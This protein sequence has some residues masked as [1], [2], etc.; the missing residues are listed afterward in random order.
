M[1]PHGRLGAQVRFAAEVGQAGSQGRLRHPVRRGYADRPGVDFALP[2]EYWS[3]NSSV[4]LSW[5]HWG[6]KAA[7]QSVVL[8]I[9]VSGSSQPRPVPVAK[10]RPE[11]HKAEVGFFNL[12][13]I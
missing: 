6:T 12:K 2:C 4:A 1:P 13:L 5:Q 3:I 11:S 9:A 7:R 8:R 10:C